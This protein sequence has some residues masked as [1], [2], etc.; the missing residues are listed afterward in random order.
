M[1]ISSL[2]V[3]KVFTSKMKSITSKYRFVTTYIKPFHI[4]NL[5][6]SLVSVI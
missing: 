6:Q 3:Y 1:I 4:V 5:V 2:E